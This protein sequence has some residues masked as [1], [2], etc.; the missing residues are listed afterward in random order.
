MAGL[1]F[2]KRRVASR[3][4]NAILEADARFSLVDVSLS[5][6]VLLG[7]ALDRTLG[8]WWAGPT[9]AFRVAGWAVREGVERLGSRL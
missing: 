9:V 5:A 6:A 1:G 4:G 2:A 7:L 3:I 8:R